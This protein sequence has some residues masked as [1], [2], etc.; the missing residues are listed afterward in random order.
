MDTVRKYI[1]KSVLQ[2]DLFLPVFMEKYKST[3]R[4]NKGHG[5]KIIKFHMMKHLCNDILRLG[6]PRVYY[7]GVGEN[8]L[9]EKNKRFARKAKKT[10]EHFEI[11]TAKGDVENILLSRA[12][13]EVN[14][15]TEVVS[16]QHGRKGLHFLMKKNS[17]N[18][19]VFVYARSSWKK[20]TEKW[21]G[22]LTLHEFETFVERFRMNGGTSIEFFTE[23]QFG[24]YKLRG[25][26]FYNKEA[27]QDWVIVNYNGKDVKVQLLIFMKIP[28]GCLSHIRETDMDNAEEEGGMY[29]MVHSTLINN[30]YANKSILAYGQQYNSFK[31]FEDS[32][33]IQWNCKVTKQIFS[34]KSLHYA[35]SNRKH[36]KPVVSL[37]KLTNIKEVIIGIPDHK[38][39]I[40]FGYLFLPCKRSWN[41]ILLDY[42]QDFSNHDKINNDSGDD[43]DNSNL[44]EE[45]SRER[46]GSD[47]SGDDSSGEGGSDDIDDSSGDSV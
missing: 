32:L 17:K 40:P 4:R 30:D 47:D 5:L 25:H 2:M 24:E 38:C 36:L 27:W 23:Y 43:S 15:A 14:G 16:I 3:I 44:E 45:N 18:E 1:K 34:W 20:L 6:P 13:Q 31:V 12:N 41:R 26:P 28:V 7:G 42:I 9:K 29:A 37:V 46:D 21:K 33:L 22:S 35:T 11:T 8:M 19:T 39:E 10:E